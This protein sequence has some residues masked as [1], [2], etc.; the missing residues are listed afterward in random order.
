MDFRTIEV[1]TAGSGVATLA[2]NRPDRHNAISDAMANELRAA[3]DSFAVDT[4]VRVVV[5]TGRG[6]TFC[7]GGDLAWFLASFGESI[8]ARVERSRLLGELF[9]AIDAFP[10]PLIGRINGPALGAGNGLLAVC[11]VAVG[12]ER[13]VFGFSE[14]RIGLIPATFSPYVIRRIGPARARSVMLSGARFDAAKACRIGL[15]D[16]VCADEASLDETVAQLAQDHL[17]ASSVAVALTKEL[18]GRVAECDV[19]TA[20]EWVAGKVGEVW[21]H[22]DAEIRIRRMLAKSDEGTR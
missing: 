18:V 1:E 17:E 16:E 13:C 12:L 15:L 7:S 10:K 22:G 5:L 14:T 4:S 3:F 19:D 21:S 8:E 2:L 20:R 11:D 6:R 9:A